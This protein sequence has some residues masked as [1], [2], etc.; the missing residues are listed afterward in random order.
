MVAPWRGSKAEERI[1]RVVNARMP[2]L[3][4]LLQKEKPC[5]GRRCRWTEGTSSKR[6]LYVFFHGLGLRHK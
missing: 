1:G 6:L 5:P 3:V 4:L 2:G